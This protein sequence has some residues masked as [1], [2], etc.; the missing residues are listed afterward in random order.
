MN[1]KKLRNNVERWLIQDNYSFKEIDSKDDNFKMHINH[2]GSFANSMEIFEP[3][4][5][6]KIFW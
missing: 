2:V 3:K 5:N 4:K 1:E 6:N